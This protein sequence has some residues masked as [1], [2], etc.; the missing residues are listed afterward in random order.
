M[1]SGP[2]KASRYERFVATLSMRT[3]T[4]GPPCYNE[5]G[6]VRELY[7][8]VRAAISTAGDYRYEHTFI[9]NPS[10]DNT[11]SQLKAIAAQDKNVKVIRNTRNFG[12]IR[13]PM[14]A[15]YQ[16]SGDAIISIVAELQD[17]PEMIVEIGRA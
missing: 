12:H 8:R 15:F 17:P 7:E 14:H 13:S 6:N 2:K 5:E 1:N 9:D 10:R 4:L 16:A 11:F 3:L